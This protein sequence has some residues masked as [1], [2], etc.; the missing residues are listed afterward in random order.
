MRCWAEIDLQAIRDNILT[1]KRIS[2]AKRV[3]AAVKANAYGHGAVAVSKAI[4]DIV[5]FLLVA[6]IDEAVELQDN[7]IRNSILILGVLIDESD[8]EEAVRRGI[9]FNLSNEIVYRHAVNVAQKL[10][11]PAVVHME[12]D[13]GMTR[14]GFGIDEGVEILR[15]L[16]EQSDVLLEGVFTHYATADVD[17]EFAKIQLERFST[18]VVPRVRQLFPNAIVHSANSA[19]SVRLKDAVFDMIRPGISIYGLLP[20]VQMASEMEFLKPAMT[21]K[22]RILQ[23]RKVPPGVG[24]SYGLTFKTKKPS[25]IGVMGVGYGDG[26]PRVLSNRAEVIVKGRRAPI[27][28]RVC[29][30]LTMVDLTHL[31]D[32]RVGD[33]VVLMG[34]DGDE[35]ITAEE[36]GELAGT[37]NYEIVTRMMP[38]TKRVYKNWPPAEETG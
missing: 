1:I 15:K 20:D 36:L 27:A 23:L 26:Y 32:V 34:A 24:I 13:T 33:E 25:L 9:R 19:A 29:M 18:R 37:I 38:R 2:G 35:R 31:T 3:A 12:F 11:R 22:T 14:T 7:G 16:T 10:G 28:G 8:V 21:W 17:I 30:D 5:D 4:S 6:T